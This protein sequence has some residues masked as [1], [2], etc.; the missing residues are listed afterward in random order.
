[1]LVYSPGG[2]LE[3]P[4]DTPHSEVPALMSEGK[5]KGFH[6]QLEEGEILILSS[7]IWILSGDCFLKPFA[8]VPFGCRDTL[9]LAALTLSSFVSFLNSYFEW[10]V[11]PIPQS[12]ITFRPSSIIPASE[13]NSH[14]YTHY[15]LIS[16]PPV[17]IYTK[18]GR[19]TRHQGAWTQSVNARP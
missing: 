3:V 18:V 11:L 6:R 5:S 9:A 4:P 10:K 8:R 14:K 16:K 7:A 12:M 19:T 15:Q 17:C 1:M 13:I 2:M